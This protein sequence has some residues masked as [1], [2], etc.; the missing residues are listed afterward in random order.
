MKKEETIQEEV[1][2][3]EKSEMEL[4]QDK[5]SELE[6]ELEITKNAY[7]KAYADTE[8]TKK[9]LMQEADNQRKYRIQDFLNQI[10]P[11]LDTLDRSLLLEG[12]DEQFIK[13]K[14]GITMMKDSLYAALVNEGVEE[15]S[16]EGEFDPT[17]HQA[18][19]TE[20]KEGVEPNQVLEVLQKGYK[21]KDRVIRASLVKVSE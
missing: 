20:A 12:E 19:L 9:R 4:L 11:I 13:L 17:L 3:V 10:L 14:T 7:F 1:V 15:I 21:L 5:I 8:N 6:K 16:A 2:E 18:L